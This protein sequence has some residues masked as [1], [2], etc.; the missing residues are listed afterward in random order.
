[1]LLSIREMQSKTPTKCHLTLVRVAVIKKS[2]DN[3]FWTRYMRKENLLSD[4]VG[5]N[6]NQC[7]HCEKQYGGSLEAK[8]RATI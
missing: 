2:S 5:G 1:M 4:P 8:N 3:K 6:I 7:S